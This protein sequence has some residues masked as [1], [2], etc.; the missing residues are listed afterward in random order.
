MGK[1]CDLCGD[2]DKEVS[3]DGIKHVS[4]H[5]LIDGKWYS[6]HHA[7]LCPS[8]R[9]KV[10]CCQDKIPSIVCNTDEVCKRCGLPNHLCVCEEVENE[11]L[12]MEKFK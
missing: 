6:G 4:I 8:C 10:F 9:E 5:N 11:K 12:K 1:Y 7:D 3:C 2:T